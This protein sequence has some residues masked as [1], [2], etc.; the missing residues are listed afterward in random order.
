MLHLLKEL[1]APVR[2]MAEMSAVWDGGPVSLTTRGI[3]LGTRIASNLGWRPVEDLVT[4]DHV[5]TFDDGPQVI[6]HVRRHVLWDGRG[7]CPR[8]LHP[9]RLFAGTCDLTRDVTVLPGQAVMIESDAAEAVTGDPFALVSASA[10]RGMQ[11]A[12]R[13][14]VD[15][16][17]EV[18]ELFFET[19]EVIHAEGGLLLFCP[20]LPDAV[21]REAGVYDIQ[22][23]EAAAV[24]VATMTR[25]CLMRPMAA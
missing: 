20:A 11:G 2:K 1:R 24:M 19:D 12:G 23:K 17:I 8:H 3:L 5:L 16:P 25:H 14:H 6:R 4:G 7:E 15:G 18:V 13:L 10:L 22:S 21:E 9:I